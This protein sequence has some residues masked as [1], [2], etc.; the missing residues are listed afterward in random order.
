M[1]LA[2]PPAWQPKA[3]VQHVGQMCQWVLTIPIVPHEEIS[4]KRARYRHYHA[5]SLK[6]IAN[7]ASPYDVLKDF[8]TQLRFTAMCNGPTRYAV[9]SV[10]VTASDVPDVIDV[11][12]TVVMDLDGPTT[13]ERV[14]FPY[15]SNAKWMM[16]ERPGDNDRLVWDT[17]GSINSENG[18]AIPLPPPSPTGPQL[19]TGAS[20]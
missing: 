9:Q 17:I 11:V 13:I 8:L 16:L 18:P 2:L 19:P 14:E 7:G 20:L 10:D 5:V 15:G 4:A 6:A 3:L 12:T 1:A